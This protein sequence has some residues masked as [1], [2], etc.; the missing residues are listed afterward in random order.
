MPKSNVEDNA[1]QLPQIPEEYDMYADAKT[2]AEDEAALATLS[3][4][5]PTKNQG[6]EPVKESEPESSRIEEEAEEP[7]EPEQPES[8]DVQALQ[9]ELAAQRLENKR[10][11]SRAKED[12]E[13]TE[14]TTRR[15][16]ELEAEIKALKEQVKPKAENKDPYAQFS[17]D[18]LRASVI[19][20]E[21]KRLE[22]LSNGDKDLARKYSIGLEQIR[23][24]LGARK[25]KASEAQRTE[26]SQKQTLE[27]EMDAFNQY[28]VERL[29]DIADKS[30]KLYQGSLKRYQES[31]LCQLLG[32][33]IGTYVAIAKTLIEDGGSGKGSPTKTRTKLL[34]DVE[35]GLD[36]KIH[37]PGARTSP[38]PTD[39]NVS[40]LS[41]K[42]FDDLYEKLEAGELVMERKP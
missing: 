3:E 21:E 38:G 33:E 39:L 5:T 9:K 27:T 25:Y 6:D 40:A 4:K 8:T 34:Q 17:D 23:E 41:E 10:L 20:F 14:S 35:E 24:E 31:K 16:Q 15:Y 30:S 19:E 26:T 2:D 13:S 18:T 28:L 11:K 36:K 7:E 29:P 32:P 1:P 12:R 37:S 22:A 42:E